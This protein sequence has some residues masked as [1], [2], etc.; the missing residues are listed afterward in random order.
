MTTANLDTAEMLEA[1]VEGDPSVRCKL[2]FLI[3][4]HN[5]STSSTSLLFEIA[6]GYAAPTHQDSADEIAVILQGSGEVTIGDQTVSVNAGDMAL[7]PRM[8]PHGVR[9]AGQETMRILTFLPAATVANV[10]E[11][12]LAPFNQR[13][14][15][16]LD[17]LVATG[18]L[19]APE[20]VP[21]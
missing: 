19:P 21:A 15:G 10:F 12:P 11:K 18:I 6:P 9:N 8:V 20:R 13:V 1:W 7:L 14:L 5:G 4:S 3:G 2:G 17:W 16:S